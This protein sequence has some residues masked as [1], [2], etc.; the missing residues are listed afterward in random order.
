[1]TCTV[2]VCDDEPTL[3]AEWIQRICDIAPASAY[4]IRPAPGNEQ[5]AE[6]VKVLLKRRHAA[7]QGAARPAD[8]CLFDGVDI[9]VVDYDLLH[10]DEDNARYTGEGVARL[11]RSF[12]DCA[13]VVVLNQ[14]PEAQFDLS[15]RGHLIS[16]ADLN[17]DVELLGTDG[18]WRP[19]PWKDFR[20]WSWQ[21][22]SESVA[23][24]RDRT[25][26]IANDLDAK[27]VDILGMT[28]ADAARLS[29]SAFG[30]LAPAAGDFAALATQSF[31]GFVEHASDGR[32]A[33]ALLERDPRAAAALAAAR[34][35]KWLEREVLGPQDVL[36][37]IP[38]LL[39]RYPF[40]VAGDVTD[41][42]AWNAAMEDEA[43]LRARLPD[44]LWFDAPNWL[45]RPAL[46]WRRLETDA[47]I[48]KQ[49]LEF[50]FS[51]VPDIAFLEDV[52]S[53]C[54]IE[55]ARDFRAGFHNSFDR[56]FAKVVD[57]IRYAP[58][59]RL[60]FGG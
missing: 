26:V 4:A 15:L 46:W 58:Q 36:V 1:M 52:S 23:R 24:Q 9:L 21:V 25:E 12:A 35:S 7:R 37:D 13:I 2:L 14:F 40:L 55:A 57:G 48:R 54:P 47:D 5:I 18:L 51:R 27:V 41:I 28:A 31:R 42:D 34:I 39:Q 60:A 20:P 10:V 11:A 50:D 44:G 17:I 59:R 30:F 49:R 56:R 45:S 38:H 3:A 29:D 16:H 33:I 32:D 53:F 19:R 22:L 6:G 8:P 43:A